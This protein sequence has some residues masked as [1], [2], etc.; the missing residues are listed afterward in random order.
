MF[1]KKILFYFLFLNT[2]SFAETYSTVDKVI[3]GDTIYFKNNNREIKCRLAFVDTPESFNNGKSESDLK[4][5]LNIGKTEMSQAGKLATQ[6]TKK[7][8]KK[9]E[10]HK[11]N[12]IGSDKYGRSICIIDDFNLTL[13]E[14]GYAVPFYKYIPKTK[15]RDFDVAIKKAK[16]NKKGLWKSHPEVMRCLTAK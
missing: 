1:T 9:G 8:L 4:K 10:K 3:D 2:L 11:I 15:V 16:I 14:E 6:Y 7:V 13:I 5:C 12:I